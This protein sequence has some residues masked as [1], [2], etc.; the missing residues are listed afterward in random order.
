MKVLSKQPQKKN[1]QPQLSSD[2]SKYLHSL[3]IVNFHKEIYWANK[4]DMLPIKVG[5]R[6][7]LCGLCRSLHSTNRKAFFHILFDLTNY[8]F[9]I[10]ST[11]LQ[12][13]TT[14]ENLPSTRT[15]VQLYSRY[16]SPENKNILNLNFKWTKTWKPSF[17][18]HLVKDCNKN[19]NSMLLN[20]QR[21]WDVCQFQS[22]LCRNDLASGFIFTA[23][24]TYDRWN[25][26]ILK[27]SH[28]LHLLKRL[29]YW[30]LAQEI[31]LG[32]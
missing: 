22:N 21:W 10:L 25:C 30:T 19:Q 17:L 9:V 3:L 32:V 31:S 24:F 12:Y 1:K 2:S 23:V 29:K 5:K 26:T 20:I 14:E 13:Y 11:W 28:V 8:I 15:L 27:N 6:I 7:L 16:L 18:H 4:N